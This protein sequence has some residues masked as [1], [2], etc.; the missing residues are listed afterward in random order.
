MRCSLGIVNEILW[1]TIGETS[2]QSFYY[3]AYDTIRQST[4]VVHLLANW[5][6]NAYN[7]LA[8][9]LILL[10]STKR[11]RFRGWSVHCHTWRISRSKFGGYFFEYAPT[12][13]LTACDMGRVRFTVSFS[14]Y[15]LTEH[16]DFY[17]VPIVLLW[18]NIP[19]IILISLQLNSWSNSFPCSI[20]LSWVTPAR[21]N[22]SSSR[23]FHLITV[24]SELMPWP[25]S[26]GALLELRSKMVCLTN[27]DYLSVSGPLRPIDPQ[28][29]L[30]LHSGGNFLLLSTTAVYGMSDNTY[31]FTRTSKMFIIFQAQRYRTRIFKSRMPYVGRLGGT[32]TNACIMNTL[33]G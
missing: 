15:L 27:V 26:P 23:R 10:H 17:L 28:R 25:L 22:V 24:P 19:W 1:G 8:V 13:V 11:N 30:A 21:K 32:Y 16:E 33:E 29:L 3:A 20:W 12:D 7:R 2:V 14:Q 6:S 9:P 5:G 31:Y 18:T 4:Y